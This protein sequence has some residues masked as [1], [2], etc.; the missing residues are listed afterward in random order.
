MTVWDRQLC[1]VL[2][3][4]VILDRKMEELWKLS[5]PLRVRETVLIGRRSGSV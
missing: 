1:R 3:L 2:T 4:C 5:S